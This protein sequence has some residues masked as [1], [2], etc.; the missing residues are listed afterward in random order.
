MT[1]RSQ[2]PHHCDLIL[3]DISA[4]L[5]QA[6]LVYTVPK[7]CW[8]EGK[9]GCAGRSGWPSAWLAGAEHGPVGFAAWDVYSACGKYQGRDPK[10]P[11]QQLPKAPRVSLLS[12]LG[13]V[14]QPRC[15]Q[16]PAL[17]SLRVQCL[18]SSVCVCTR[19]YPVPGSPGKHFGASMEKFS[20]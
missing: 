12:A 20:S 5:P 16:V 3:Q 9:P 6:G 7:V 11:L 2:E 4:G 14:P 10:V 15:P 13:S 8:G 18:G 17:L 1:R 19:V